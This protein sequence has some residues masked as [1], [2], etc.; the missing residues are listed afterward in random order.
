MRLERFVDH[1][2][3]HKD[4]MQT[5]VKTTRKTVG[6]CRQCIQTQA[7][8]QTGSRALGAGDG[9]GALAELLR[10]A[11]LVLGDVGGEGAP[12]QCQR[13]G[14]PGQREFVQPAPQ[15]LQPRLL[16]AASCTPLATWLRL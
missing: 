3:A 13:R 8:W 2:R 16:P 10:G 11:V 6:L 14:Q 5:F 12:Q 9:A 15:Q 1:R 4:A 7:R